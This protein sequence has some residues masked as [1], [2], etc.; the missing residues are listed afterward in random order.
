MSQNNLEENHR[1]CDLN[2]RHEHDHHGRTESSSKNVV[3]AYYPRGRGKF[4]QNH[5]APA[6]LNLIVWFSHMT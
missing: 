4:G 6:L 2:K 1:V 3:F 5:Q